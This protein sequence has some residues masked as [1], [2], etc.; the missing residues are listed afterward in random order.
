MSGNRRGQSICFYDR[1]STGTEHFIKGTAKDLTL[2][3]MPDASVEDWG[4]VGTAQ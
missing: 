1:R 3:S 2:R 4:T